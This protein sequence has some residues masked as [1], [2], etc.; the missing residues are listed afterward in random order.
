M[1][2]S[3]WKAT[4]RAIASRIGG[5]RVPVSGRQR[6]DQPDVRHDW[7]AVE[8]KH[9]RSIPQWLTTALKQAHAA[10]RGDQLPVAI[11][12]RH[13]ARHT[14]DIVC[15]RLA[16]FVQWFGPVDESAGE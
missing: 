4:E 7:L 3:R 14:E 9:R 2:R 8:V 13:G 1:S 15:L 6:R 11:I 12:H 10:V 5:E 16:D